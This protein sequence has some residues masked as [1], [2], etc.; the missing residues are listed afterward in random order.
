VHGQVLH[1]MRATDP[2]MSWM[3]VTALLVPSG[4]AAAQVVARHG[5]AMAWMAI[6]GCL[7][8]HP[9]PVRAEDIEHPV[10]LRIDLDPM[11]GIEWPQ[12]RD[13]ARV[14]R[15]VLADFGLVGWP[16]T[17]RSRGI[18]VDARIHRL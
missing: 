8:L 9:H 17:S 5:A 13:V 7:A 4:G 15:E 12:I 16:K 2:P 1:Q 18:H 14:V 11:P 6:V 3:E 10:E